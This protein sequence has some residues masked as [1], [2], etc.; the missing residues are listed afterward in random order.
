MHRRKSTWSTKGV[1]QVSALGQKR[2]LTASLDHGI[3]LRQQCRWH[4]EAEGLCGLEI[5]HQFVLGRRLH[6]QVG[7]LLTFEDA[8]DVAGRASVRLDR[9]RSVGNQATAGD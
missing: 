4:D 9:V 7:G 3:G 6:R 5:Y 2:T 8:I 1:V